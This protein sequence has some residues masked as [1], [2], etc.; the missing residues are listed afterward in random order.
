MLSNNLKTYIANI[1]PFFRSLKIYIYIYI[2]SDQTDLNNDLSP[3]AMKE[4]VLKFEWAV[5]TKHFLINLSG[6]AMTPPISHFR[7]VP[8]TC[9]R[10]NTKTAPVIGIDFIN[11]LCMVNSSIA[12]SGKKIMTIVSDTWRNRIGRRH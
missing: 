1:G 7:F 4:T 10:R 11:T 8:V 2:M 5:N 6:L 12:H 9:T 3:E